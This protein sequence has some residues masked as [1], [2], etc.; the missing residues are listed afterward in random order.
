MTLATVEMR[1][2]LEHRKQSVKFLLNLNSAKIRK[3]ESA[4]EK[5][6]L[7]HVILSGIGIAMIFNLGHLRDVL[8]RYFAQEQYNAQAVAAVLLP[9]FLYQFMRLGQLLTASNAAR[10]LQ[11]ELLKDY[12]AGT[13]RNLNLHPLHTSTSFLAESFATGAAGNLF[14]PYLL[15]T[16]AIVSI[17]QAAA[18]FLVVQAYGVNR[19]SVAALAASAVALVILYVLFWRSQVRTDRRRATL[20]IGLALLFFLSAVSL[21]IAF[22]HPTRGDQPRNI[23]FCSEP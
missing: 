19:F 10:Q 22:G 3:L 15:V 8:A 9:V 12:L 23:L 17:A 18:L 5:N 2:E 14:W 11:D 13:S 1:R 4:L 6:W 16:S 21:L 20:A 7:V